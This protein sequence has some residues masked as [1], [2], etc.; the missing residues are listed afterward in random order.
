MRDYSVQMRMIGFLHRLYLK[1]KI[2]LHVGELVLGL[3]PR[4]GLRFH[5]R[6]A[7]EVAHAN[8][9]GHGVD[10]RY[11]DQSQQLLQEMAKKQILVEINLSSNA[12][13]LNVT[14]QQHPIL[15][16]RQHHVPVALSTD[17]EGGC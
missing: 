14:G 13:I 12:A 10:I 4:S 11:E 6:E 3:V 5:I 2:S 8:R 9:I 17:D 7:I 15:L 16:Y 1:V